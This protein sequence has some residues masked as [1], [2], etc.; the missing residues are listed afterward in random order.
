MQ[1]FRFAFVSLMLIC[2][3]VNPP[4]AVDAETLVYKTVDGHRESVPHRQRLVDAG[5]TTVSFDYRLV[6]E[7]KLPEIIKDFEDAFS[8]LHKNGS[9]HKL[10]TSKV[11]VISG[12]AGGYL[13]LVSGYRAKPKPTVLISFWGYGD[14]VGDWYSKPSPPLR[15]HRIKITRKEAFEQVAGPVVSDSRER[16]GNGEAF[17]QYCRQQ[18][19]W[20]KAVSGWDPVTEKEKFYPYMPVKNVTKDYPPPISIHRTKDT[21]APYDL[22]M[23]MAEQFKKQGVEHKLVTVQNDEHGLGS[24]KREEITAAHNAAIEFLNEHMRN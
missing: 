10:D 17:Y 3:L 7:T 16:K 13:T 21:D 22:S 24:A 2:P 8:W 20:P 6:P 14:L 23:M 11:A 5:Y 9:K 19:I 15:R 4:F 1:L 18:G 12:S